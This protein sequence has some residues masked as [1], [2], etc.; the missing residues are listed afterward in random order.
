MFLGRKILIFDVFMF[1]L[2]RDI[3]EATWHDLV[4][5]TISDSFTFPISN[6]HTSISLVHLLIWYLVAT[7]FPAVKCHQF[8]VLLDLAAKMIV[9]SEFQRSQQ[10]NLKSTLSRLLWVYLSRY[11]FSKPFLT[12][13]APT[14]EPS[15]SS[16]VTA[17]LCSLSTAWASPHL[18]LHF[19]LPRIVGSAVGAW[20]GRENAV[21]GSLDVQ[22]LLPP[23]LCPL[24]D[25]G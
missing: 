15:G 12:H 2:F 5:V 4:L 23:C 24:L 13:E 19:L 16:F 17:G 9:L 11:P 21:V 18:C 3:W 6:C 22:P 1:Y 8:S 10:N 14:I 25:D 20:V 7:K